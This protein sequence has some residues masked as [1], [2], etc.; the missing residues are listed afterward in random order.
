VK[1]SGYK[2]LEDRSNETKVAY[3]DEGNPEPIYSESVTVVVA[4]NDPQQVQLI[5]ENKELL[6]MVLSPNNS[7]AT[8][9]IDSENW[10]S[11]VERLEKL[12]DAIQSEPLKTALQLKVS[13]IDAA[14][15]GR[16]TDQQSTNCARSAQAS[17][18]HQR[19][20]PSFGARVAGPVVALRILF[21]REQS[22]FLKAIL[23]I[24]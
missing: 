23:P 7:A 8:T 2:A 3:T 18:R 24:R 21:T 5:F 13:C 16:V 15:S 10:E 19:I 4:P 14:Y 9:S 22:R 6:W 20:N 11:I 17:H 12:G 1:H